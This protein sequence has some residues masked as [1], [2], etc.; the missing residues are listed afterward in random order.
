MV[1]YTTRPDRTKTSSATIAIR[2]VTS[3]GWTLALASVHHLLYYQP[4]NTSS[5]KIRK[6]TFTK[7]K[8][9]CVFSVTEYT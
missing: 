6:I 8:V 1:P 4:E 2:R 5:H 7:P 3:P 9:T